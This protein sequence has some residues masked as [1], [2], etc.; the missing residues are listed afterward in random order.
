MSRGKSIQYVVIF[1]NEVERDKKSGPA[2]PQMGITKTKGEQQLI[3]G[4]KVGRDLIPS[5]RIQPPG[6]IHSFET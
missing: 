2:T 6:A 4:A 1:G 5:I 3:L